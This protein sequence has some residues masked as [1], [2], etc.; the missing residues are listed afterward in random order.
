MQDN[1]LGFEIVNIIDEPRTYSRL[2][3]EVSVVILK[4]CKLSARL[5][6]DVTLTPHWLKGLS[7]ANKDPGTEG[8]AL[9]IQG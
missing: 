3:L 4:Q 8:I 6:F 1:I 2:S 5:F 7:W 9:T